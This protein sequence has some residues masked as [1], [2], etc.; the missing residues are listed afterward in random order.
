MK[1]RKIYT[2]IGKEAEMYLILPTV[3]GDAP[4]VS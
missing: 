3:N 2:P 4:K 1:Q